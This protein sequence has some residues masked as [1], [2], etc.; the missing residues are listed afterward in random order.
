[1]TGKPIVPL[2][3]LHKIARKP[4]TPVYFRTIPGSERVSIIAKK[5]R[6]MLEIEMFLFGE[7]KSKEAKLELYLQQH[8]NAKL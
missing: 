1:M 3:E 6:S 2:A 7:P 8:P 5:G 4:E